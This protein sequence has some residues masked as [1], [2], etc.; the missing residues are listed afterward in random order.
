[1]TAPQRIQNKF[2]KEQKNLI[3]TMKKLEHQK[4]TRLRQLNEEK[5]QFSL[6]MKK[7]LSRTVS[8]RRGSSSATERGSQRTYISVKFSPL[9]SSK[10][11]LNSADA[12][13]DSKAVSNSPSA[14]TQDLPASRTSKF[15]KISDLSFPSAG[16]AN[17]STYLHSK[18]QL[19]RRKNNL[20]FL[21]Q[22]GS[23]NFP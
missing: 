23:P 21:S 16:P 22:T 20:P 17:I 11:S 15:C 18:Q 10:S 13:P 1:M 12:K 4:L 2:L 9:A 3:T 6:L 14:G 8:V 19:T 5:R 7:R